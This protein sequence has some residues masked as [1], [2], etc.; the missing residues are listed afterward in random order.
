[1]SLLITPTELADGMKTGV[2]TTLLASMWLPGREDAGF[3]YYRGKHIPNSLFC[4]PA[5]A[6]TSAPS[7]KLGRN[8]LPDPVILQKWFERW[9]LNPDH[10]VV[11]YDG[12]RGL[13]AARA[14]WVLT[15]AGIRGV[16][17]LDGGLAA[18]VRE[19]RR[20]AGGPGN[21][22]QTC[23]LRVNP[24]QLPVASIDDVKSFDGVLLD[25]R[26]ENRFAGRKERL[27]L[28]AGHIPGAVNLPAGR[29]SNADKT[30]RSP[31]E[32]RAEFEAV[33]VVDPSRVIVYSGSGLHSAR[34]VAAMHYA[35][36]PGAAVYVG[37]WSQWCADP[38]NPVATT[39]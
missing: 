26:Q 3:Q 24:G 1:M 4:D 12:G 27:D 28:K 10:R 30:F 23:T 39:V 2:K 16:R 14:W 37:G 32:I 6:L 19:G 18:W 9:G 13:M 31:G 11:V 25:V 17:I 29:L 38:K 8:P 5:R 21:L 36:L 20:H 34:A 15:W 22:P 33:G 35:G 7:S